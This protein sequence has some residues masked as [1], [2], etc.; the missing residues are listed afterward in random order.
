VEVPLALGQLPNVVGIDSLMPIHKFARMI[1]PVTYW[2]VQ[3]AIL[4]RPLALATLTVVLYATIETTS[5]A[6]P[7]E[8]LITE[9][10]VPSEITFAVLDSPLNR[11]PSLLQL[12]LPQWDLLAL[13]L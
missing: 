11:P 3:S 8:V 2:S 12:W 4:E 1:L 6:V 13:P 10:F 5:L 9:Y 7:P